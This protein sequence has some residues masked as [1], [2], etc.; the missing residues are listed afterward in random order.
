MIND[1]SFKPSLSLNQTWWHTCWDDVHAEMTTMLRWHPRWDDIHAEMTSMLRWHPCWDEIHAE[2]TSM[3]RWHPFWDDNHAEMTSMLRWH[4][5]WDDI[6]A[7][8]TE[9]TEMTE[10]HPDTWYLKK[11]F[12]PSC[13]KPSWFKPS[14]FKPSLHHEA[15]CDVTWLTQP[16]VE[17]LIASKK[18]SQI[19][20]HWILLWPKILILF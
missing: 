8:M 1:T 7:E 15:S 2:I 12:K 17:M 20:D 6:H 16:T 9:M 5:C 14:C 19:T 11:L 13:F 10:T 18:E 4:P 3:L